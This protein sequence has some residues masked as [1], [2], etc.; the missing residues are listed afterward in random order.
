MPDNSAQA[1]RDAASVAH[2]DGDTGAAVALY[3][4]IVDLFPESSEAVEAAFYL[5]GIGKSRRRTP[6]R[7]AINKP[8]V[9]T[10]ARP[11]ESPRNRRS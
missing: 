10:S 8:E 7:V 4:R 11:D 3:R 2:R 6:K 5:S 1:L 9:N